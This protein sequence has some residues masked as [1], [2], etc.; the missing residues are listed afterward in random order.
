[1]ATDTLRLSTS[2]LVSILTNK[3]QFF[4]TKLRMPA[5]SEPTTKA[6]FLYSA[7]FFSFST[8]SPAKP[9]HQYPI[10]FSFS[11]KLLILTATKISAKSIFPAEAL[12]NDGVSLAELN[13]QKTIFLKL[14]ATA[15]RIMA[16]T[17]C[18]SVI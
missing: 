1:V 12:I 17:F 15:L 4:L 7:I 3:S 13:S 6:I 14:K 11:I 9:I 10:F 8:P 16:P 18:G 5:P 2:L